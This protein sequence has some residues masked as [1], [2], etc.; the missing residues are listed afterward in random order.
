MLRV[1]GWFLLRPDAVKVLSDEGARKSLNRY[2]GILEGKYNPKF[3]IAS[4]IPVNFSTDDSLRSLW[5]IH[6]GALEEYWRLE[7]RIDSGEVRFEDIPTPQYSLLDLKAVIAHRLLEECCFCERRCRVNRVKGE[8]GFCKC[9]EV[10]L[11]SSAFHHLGEEPELVP[12]GT[13]FSIGCN[14]VCLHCQN[15]TI[16][17][18]YEAG[19]P[20]SVR[21]LARIVEKLKREGCRNCNMVGGDPTPWLHVW[22][23]AF[24]YVKTSIPTVWNSNSYYSVEASELLKGFIDVYLLDFK[25]GSDRC[26]ERI[27]SA[28]R[29]VEVCRRNHLKAMK[30][31]ELIIR[32]LLLPEHIEC[33]AKPILEWIAENLGTWVRVNI[34]DQYTPHWRAYE[35]PELR[36]RLYREEY[37]EALRYARKLGFTNIV[38]P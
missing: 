30:S 31:G 33:C 5:D 12:S 7:R 23:D 2:F 9:G 29:Y 17:Q 6:R 34:M 20:I 24:R 27:S 13:V 22:I 4:R 19:D 26:A 14:L 28:P 15:W 8:V 1:M 10:F 37:E 25:Y 3:M 21:E 38:P 18:R 11:L 16:S 36:R 32:I 35:I